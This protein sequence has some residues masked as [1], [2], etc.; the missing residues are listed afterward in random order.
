MPGENN[1]LLIFLLITMMQGRPFPGENFT[2]ILLMC[3]LMQNPGFRLCD[4]K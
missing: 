1:F 2:L 4:G 3:M